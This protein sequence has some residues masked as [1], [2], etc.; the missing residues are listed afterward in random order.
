MQFVRIF[1]FVFALRTLLP[2]VTSSVPVGPNEPEK[3][4][5]LVEIPYRVDGTRICQMQSHLLVEERLVLQEGTP[6]PKPTC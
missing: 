3:G 6:S 5:I 2:L 4:V 1:R